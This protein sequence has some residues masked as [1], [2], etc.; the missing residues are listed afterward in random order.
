M[1]EIKNCPFCGSEAEVISN[2]INDTLYYKVMCK[3]RRC[4]IQSNSV[5]VGLNERFEYKTD[6][7]VSPIMAINHVIGLWNARAESPKY[8][9]EIKKVKTKVRRIEK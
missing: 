4:G 7:Q 1:E 3:N 6:V 8:P 5:K 2:N 9:W